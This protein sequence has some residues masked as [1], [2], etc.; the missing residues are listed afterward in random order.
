MTHKK[1]DSYV[2][3]LLKIK[4]YHSR[5]ACII[6]EADIKHNLSTLPLNK[7]VHRDKY[8]LALYILERV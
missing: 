5:L 6:K 1:E 2:D 3:Y 8:M 4:K 7:M